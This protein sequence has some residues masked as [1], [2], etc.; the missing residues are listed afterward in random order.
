VGKTGQR[1]NR[2]LLMV[3]MVL[4]E[5]GLSIDVLCERLEATRDE[6]LEDLNVLW[7]C[8]LPDYT[9]ADLIDFRLEGDR[10]YL[11]MADYFKRPLTI[12]RDEALVM[13]VAGRALL[14][15]KVFKKTGPLGSALKKVESALS[16]DELG[17]VEN[18]AERIDLE[19]DACS[20]RLWGTIEGGLEKEKNLALEYYSFSRDTVTSREV[21]PLSLV[22]SKGHWYLLAWCQTAADYRLFRLDR[23]KKVRLTSRSPTR[24]APEESYMP[25]VV[26]EYRPG[27]K[28][29]TVRLKFFGK[30]GRRLVEDWPTAEFRENRDGSFTVELR[31]RNLSWLASYLLRFGDRFRVE[32]PR[33]LAKA[34]QAKASEILEAYS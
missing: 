34:V 30:E 26:G 8:G 2:I 11:E 16:R 21:E 3:P 4:E 12:T 17:D 23:I 7:M 9:P 15:A 24:K 10:V 13:F 5:E 29:H 25:E 6:L 31:T 20:G 33:E 1:L 28:S 27:K 14:E 32:S 22:W 19:I 18:V